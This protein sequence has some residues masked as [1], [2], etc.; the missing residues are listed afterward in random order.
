MREGWWSPAAISRRVAQVPHL[1]TL[2]NEGAAFV[3]GDPV[4]K[5][6]QPHLLAEP[7]ELEVLGV[8]T[9]VVHLPHP[10]IVMRNDKWRDRH[11]RWCREIGRDFVQSIIDTGASDG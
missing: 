1:L 8:R 6:A 5:D 4:A 11:E 3:R 2:G 7:V 10:G 9:R